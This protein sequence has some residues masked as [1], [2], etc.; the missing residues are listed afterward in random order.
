LQRD[1]LRRYISNENL[2]LFPDFQQRLAL[3]Q[4]TTP[5]GG[6]ARGGE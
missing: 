4:V 2:S 3:L 6:R 5:T 1:A